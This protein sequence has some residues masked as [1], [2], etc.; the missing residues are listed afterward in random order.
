MAREAGED[1]VQSKPVIGLTGGVGSGKSAVGSVL[2]E[3]GAGVID[4]DELAHEELTRKDVVDT[5]VEWWGSAVLDGAG[6]IDR[7]RVGEMVFADAARRERLEQLLHP[8]VVARTRELVRR[9]ALDP[10]IRAIVI[11]AP[12]LVE[13]ELD[14][15]LCDVVIFI[16]ADEDVRQS[17]TKRYRGWSAGEH[18]RREGSQKPLDSKR[19]RADYIVTN[20]STMDALRRQVKRVLAE[21]LI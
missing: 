1:G 3:L 17:R 15:V 12:L 6:R 21:I 19:D 13:A 11:D 14:E 4:A 2:R 9:M 20:N 18:R 16:D 10:A 8:R 7:R 5:V